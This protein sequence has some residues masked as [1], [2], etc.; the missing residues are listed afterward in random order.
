MTENIVI[1]YGKKDFEKIPTDLIHN[2]KTKF[3]ALNTE[4]HK[5]LSQN[6]IQHEI[7][8]RMINDSERIEIFDYSVRIRHW[9]E[10]KNLEKFS[11]EGINILSILD[12]NEFQSIIVKVMLNLLIIK[13][14][15]QNES[16]KRIFA[17][18]FFLEYLSNIK[19]E[20]EIQLNLWTNEHSDDAFWDNIS[21]KQKIGIIPLSVNISRFRY[22]KIKNFIENVFCSSLGY[23]F[24]F[25]NKKKDSILFLEFDP[26]TYSE[27]L[28]NLADRDHNIICCNMRNPAFRDFNSGKIFQKENI[29]ILNHQK[30]ISQENLRTIHKIEK[31]LRKE[32]DKLFDS[33]IMLEI[34]RYDLNSI[35]PIIRKKILTMYKNRLL[36][37]MK[38]ALIVK[39]IIHEI[40]L[41]AIVKLNDIGETEKAFMNSNN[42]NIPLI[43]LQHG[44][45]DYNDNSSRFDSTNGYSSIKD[46]IAVWGETQKKYLIE[47]RNISPEKIIVSGSP[48]HDKF[49]YQK[50]IN[51][52]RK[53]RILLAPRA[54]TEMTGEDNIDLHIKYEKLLERI[55]STVSKN[56]DI[57][58]LVK[59]HPIQLEHNNELIQFFRNLDSRIH[60]NIQS[61]VIDLIQKS[62]AVISITSEEWD[63][64]SIVLESQIMNKPILNIS[65]TD[66]RS[67]FQCVKENS[68]ISMTDNDNIEGAINDILFDDKTIKRLKQNTEEYLKKYLANHGNASKKF[69]E[70]LTAIKK[71][72]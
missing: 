3:F 17:S 22:K 11:F 40:N 63:L 39:K 65:P 13:K 1:V 26:Y 15:I 47:K 27:L 2:K 42:K 6:K 58:L 34:F 68:I 37:Y 4:S 43:L 20:K 14:I 72:H 10:N 57:E 24:D 21:I 19:S 69:A 71:N 9:Y 66:K 67:E 51:D 50:I 44:Y 59:L 55:Y 62:D 46:T 23:W 48:K 16:P 25:K 12:D 8:D 60:V 28:T 36:E 33:E 30:L 61:S 31:D 52:S 53:K 41:K 45:T 64:S 35:W 5:L 49:F 38:M 7:P 70:Y 56:P 18:S 32:I 54:I 29:K